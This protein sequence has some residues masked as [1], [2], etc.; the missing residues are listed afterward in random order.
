MGAP[1]TNIPVF[2]SVKGLMG[3]SMLFWEEHVQVLLGAQSVLVR[4]PE[5]RESSGTKRWAANSV[6]VSAID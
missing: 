6:G 3:K 4:T 1:Q 5:F 2:V